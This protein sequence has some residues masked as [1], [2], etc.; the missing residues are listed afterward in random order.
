MQL[1]CIKYRF[2]AGRWRLKFFDELI[3]Q[4]MHA[5][6]RYRYGTMPVVTQASSKS[7]CA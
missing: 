7:E 6:Y 2:E 5:M 4:E 1:E 3:E